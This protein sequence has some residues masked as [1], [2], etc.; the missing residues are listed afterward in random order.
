MTIPPNWSALNQANWDERVPVHLDPNSGY[1]LTALRSG[2]ARLDTIAANI[3]GP[4]EGMRVLH[5][6]CHFGKDTL[7]I[8]QAGAPGGAQA[9]AQPGAQA[10][11][12]VTGLDFSPPAIEAARSL[13]IEVGLA[14]RAR[15]VVANVYDAPSALPE[16]ESFDRVFVSWGALCW[17][18]DMPYWARIVASFLKPGGFLALAE[19]HPAA[20]VFD[21]LTA[22]PD[23]RPGW[24]MPYLGREPLMEDRP[25]D[26]ANPTARLRNSRT[27]EFLHP[28]SD[29]M[30]A[31]I[32]SGLRID[33]FLE[34]DSVVWEM[35]GSLVRR[36]R[37]EYVWPDK[38]WLPL[39]YS[40]RAVKG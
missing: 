18:P 25:E 9:G 6:Q 11:V 38:P 10:G 16:P 29:I 7:T 39:S 14:D 12:Q 34:H 1:D 32:D 37:S 13:A 21:D 35:F 27:V 23:G 30:M 17:L 31:L 8:A 19:A 20:Y 22:T 15:F 40:L 26:Y 2:T 24:Y 36:S 28:L 3:L 5:L 33:R 4:V